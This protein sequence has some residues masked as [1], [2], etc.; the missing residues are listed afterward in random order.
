MSVPPRHLTLN[1]RTIFLVTTLVAIALIPFAHRPTKRVDFDPS[2]VFIKQ[3]HGKLPGVY[4]TTVHFEKHYQE[5]YRDYEP[6]GDLDEFI[7]SSDLGPNVRFSSQ[8][9]SKLPIPEQALK[10]Y[11]SLLKIIGHD[12]IEFVKW[13]DPKS[14]FWSQAPAEEHIDRLRD[15]HQ[16]RRSLSPSHKPSLSASDRKKYSLLQ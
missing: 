6:F 13:M 4:E 16:I 2:L 7:A 5:F 12:E 15:W 9:K 3:K 14:D 1:L 10:N 8:D 11:E